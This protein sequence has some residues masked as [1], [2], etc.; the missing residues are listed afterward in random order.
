MT[1]QEVDISSTP[2][3]EQT[4]VKRKK[5]CDTGAKK[6]QKTDSEIISEIPDESDP[7]RK[8]YHNAVEKKRRDKMNTY[9]QGIRLLILDPLD[10]PN[11][12]SDK[13]SILKATFQYLCKMRGIPNVSS[14]TER[15]S[16]L[17]D[18]EIQNII[19]KMDCSFI[20]VTDALE[21][22]LVW[23]HGLDAHLGYEPGELFGTNIFGII[24]HDDI[25]TYKLNSTP[26]SFGSISVTNKRSFICNFIR[27]VISTAAYKTNPLD[28]FQYLPVILSGEVEE[29]KTN[30]LLGEK[31]AASGLGECMKCFVAIGQGLNNEV[32]DVT[33]GMRGNVRVLS[34][35]GPDGKIEFVHDAIFYIIGYTPSELNG[36][37]LFEFVHPHDSRRLYNSLYEASSIRM[38]TENIIIRLKHKSAVY[39][40]VSIKRLA[41]RHPT[42]DVVAAFISCMD[43]T[44][45]DVESWD[46]TFPVEEPILEQLYDPMSMICQGTFAPQLLPHELGLNPVEIPNYPNVL[47]PK[48]FGGELSTLF[49]EPILLREAVEKYEYSQNFVNKPFEG[50]LNNN[51][52][53]RYNSLMTNFVDIFTDQ[54]F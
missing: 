43:E 38:Y 22:T 34:R 18:S 4:K 41:V 8:G 29:I 45:I 16:F 46:A 49:D 2:A 32:L 24:K 17:G 14:N 52:P 1:D 37:T 47:R 15:P 28:S 39:K 20:V 12:K 6:S 44:F 13:L 5:T 11:C 48:D 30:L 10:Q 23:E 35:E 51:V 25:A 42:Q 7:H 31:V 9:I 36:H 27:K 33:Q 50:Q 21:G 19:S 54:P 3:C 26:S 53:T 40:T